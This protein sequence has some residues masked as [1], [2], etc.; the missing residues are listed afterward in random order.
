MLHERP[1]L[2]IIYDT[3]KGNVLISGTIEGKIISGLQLI[4]NHAMK[5]YREWSYTSTI[6]NVGIR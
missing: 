1:K 6:L 2:C 3:V 4:T 5:M